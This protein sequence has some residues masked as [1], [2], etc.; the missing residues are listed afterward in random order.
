MK[1]IRRFETIQKAT[2]GGSPVVNDGPFRHGETVYVVSKREL[3][4]VLKECR[5]YVLPSV[6]KTEGAEHLYRVLGEALD[7]DDFIK[8]LDFLTEDDYP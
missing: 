7:E 6:L 5:A 2:L 4:A 3:L 8:P 1:K